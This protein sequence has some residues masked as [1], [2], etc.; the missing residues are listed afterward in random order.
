MTEVMTE[1]KL[2]ARLDSLAKRLQW[3]T[4][5]EARAAWVKGYG[6]NGEFD[7]DRDRLIA[8]MEKVL[9]ALEQINGSPKF[10]PA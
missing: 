6:A 10:H 7:E 3:I 8:Q 9:D 1:E 2:N 4:D 5:T